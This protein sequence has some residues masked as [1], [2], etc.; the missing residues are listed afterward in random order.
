MFFNPCMMLN[1][2]H[3]MLGRPLIDLD[4]LF[5]SF[6]QGLEVSEGVKKM[7]YNLLRCPLQLWDMLKY[8][9]NNT[10]PEL[11]GL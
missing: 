7:I 11:A 4:W 10:K 3:M 6:W 5:H 2:F 9:Y 8:I 1:K